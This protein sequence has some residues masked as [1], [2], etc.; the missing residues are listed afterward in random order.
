AAELWRTTHDKIYNEYFVNHYP[1]YRLALDMPAPEGWRE[2]APMALWT[3]ALG[4]VKGADASLIAEIRTRTT[5]ASRAIVES[6]RKTPYRV[7][8]RAKDYVWGSNGVAA[9]Y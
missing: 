1:D 5:Q 4:A 9:N 3:Y 6:T 7:S 8:L 2:V